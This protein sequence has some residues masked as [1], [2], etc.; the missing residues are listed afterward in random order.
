MEGNADPNIVG[1]PQS[2]APLHVAAH[3]NAVETCKLLIEYGGDLSLKDEDGDT[4]LDLVTSPELKIYSLV[5]YCLS[6]CVFVLNECSIRIFLDVSVYA[7]NTYNKGFT[8]LMNKCPHY[9][10]LWL[11]SIVCYSETCS[12]K[13]E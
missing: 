7:Y 8:G 13:N 4:P 3:H 6:V 1:G 9:K 2:I 10:L 11:P 12:S 5:N